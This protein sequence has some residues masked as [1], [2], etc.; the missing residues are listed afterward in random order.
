MKAKIVVALIIVLACVSGGSGQSRDPKPGPELEKLGYF[1]GT[2]NAEGQMQP[3]IFGP[4][5]KFSNVTSNEWIQGN[6]FYISHHEEQNPA[7][8]FKELHI[9]GYDRE[10]KVY[11]TYT[12]TDDGRVDRTEGTLANNTWT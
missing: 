12:F 2:W 6:F 9:T 11:V 8:K 5:G 3:S 10:K 1:I 4:G 7:G